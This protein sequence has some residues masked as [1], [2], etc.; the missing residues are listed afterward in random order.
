MS[1][2]EGVCE[3]MKG[4]LVGVGLSDQWLKSLL[5]FPIFLFFTG[6]L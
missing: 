6:S 4:P 3:H 1:S 5:L 2:L